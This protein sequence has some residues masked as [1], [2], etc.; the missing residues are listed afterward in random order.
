MS[1]I[2]LIDKYQEL[3]KS[4]SRYFIISG[5]RGSSKSFSVATYLCLLMYFEKGHTILFTRYTLTSAHSSIIPEFTE[6]IELLGLQ[7]EFEITQTEIICKRTGSNIIF[8]GIKAS[9]G[10]NTAKLKS[11]NNVTTWIMDEAEE[12]IEEEIFD[13][14]NLSV[15]KKDI[16]NRIILI[17]N[18]TTKEHWIY[19]RFFEDKGVKPSSNLTKDD[20]TYI[21]TTYLDNIDNLDKSFIKE[22]E[23][24]KLNNPK[25]YYHQI[26]GGWLDKAEGVIF[27]NWEIGEFPIDEQFGIGLDFGYSIDP[28]AASKIIVDNKNKVIYIQEICYKQYMTTK[29]IAETLKKHVTNNLII[30]DLAEGRLIDELVKEHSLNVQKCKKGHNSVI[31]GIKLLEGFKLIIS[32]DSTNMVKELN[33]YIWNDR[34]SGTPI[35]MYNHLIDGLRYYVTSINLHSVNLPNLGIGIKNNSS[36]LPRRKKQYI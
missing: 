14:I 1:K 15:R 26:E 19:K 31:E 6:K 32:P 12:L 16:Q 28:T 10:T 20:T 25:K 8:R 22:I 36:R 24:I 5:G 27:S 13:K 9:S 18:P 30:A 7:E 35:D 23:N 29:D 4:E 34:K 11:L 2:T 21:H 17:L 33:N 3:F